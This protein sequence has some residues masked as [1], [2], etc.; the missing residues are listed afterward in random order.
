MNTHICMSNTQDYTNN[1][2]IHINTHTQG[3][4]LKKNKTSNSRAY[5]SLR[6]QAANAGPSSCCFS[7]MSLP[8]GIYFILTL[9]LLSPQFSQCIF[10]EIFRGVTED[11][12]TTR[13]CSNCWSISVH[14]SLPYSI[15]CSVE[16]ACFKPG[17]FTH[18]FSGLVCYGTAVLIPPLYCE[19]TFTDGWL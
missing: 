7:D 13:F 17:N 6:F 3:H 18:I 10:S 8:K 12:T 1:T 4:T 16:R 5:I 2:H 11:L 9:N 15:L 19:C 14:P